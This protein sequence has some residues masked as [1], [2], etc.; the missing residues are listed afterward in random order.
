MNKLFEPEI[1][2]QHERTEKDVKLQDSK[3]TGCVE[4]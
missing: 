1:E 3:N 2:R 4:P